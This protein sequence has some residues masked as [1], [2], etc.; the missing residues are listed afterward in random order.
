MPFWNAERIRYNMER[1]SQ[2]G[3][4]GGFLKCEV[5]FWDMERRTDNQEMEGV[6]RAVVGFLGHRTI[7][8]HGTKDG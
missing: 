3:G 6:G 2:T 7:L 5:T 1:N 8:A 4:W